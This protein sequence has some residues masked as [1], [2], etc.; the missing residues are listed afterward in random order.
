MALAATTL[1]GL[2]AVAAPQAAFAEDAMCRTTRGDSDFYPGPSASA[3]YDS[4]FHNS[5]EVPAGLLEGRYVPQG[6]AYWNNWNGTSED[7]LLISAYHDGNG[8]KDP[9]GPSAIFG[10][11]LSGDRR[12]T[13]LGRML[14]PTTH[15]GG[16]AMAG[17]YV[18]VGGEG[19]VRYW[20]A[21]VVR[22][23]LKGAN[24][25]STVTPKDSHGVRGKASFLGRQGGSVWI[26]DF[27]SDSHQHMWRYK[28]RDDGSLRYTDTKRWVPR[29]TQGM[30]VIGKK[31]VFGTS[32]GRSD[33]SNVWVRPT[34]LTTDITDGTSFCMR[35]PSMI[36]GL[37]YG[38]S[39]GNAHLW[40]VYESGSYTYRDSVNP[41]KNIHW[42]DGSTLAGL[43]GKAD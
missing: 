8:N 43:Y 5:V 39:N 22:N 21:K 29:K 15:A 24:S 16:I 34:S 30:A 13:G 35:A 17:G 3:T 14:I 42:A 18:Y 6:L 31:F 32:E 33:R 38:T 40:A 20:S 27:D 10:V 23:H 37:A 12:G 2:V 25:S 19:R 26:G 9:D 11:V 36:E 4:T 41:I 28:P 7:I 1:G